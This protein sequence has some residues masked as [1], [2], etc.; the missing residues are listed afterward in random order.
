MEPS[1]FHGV[2]LYQW[3][4]KAGGYRGV[5]LSGGPKSVYAEDAPKYD[6]EIFQLGLPVLGICYGMQVRNA[7]FQSF[8]SCK[9]IV[10]F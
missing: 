3:P 4:L 5:I 9:K 10:S 1:A 7:L 6:P 2:R 8:H